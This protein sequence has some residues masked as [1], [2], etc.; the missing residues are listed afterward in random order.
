MWYFFS[1]VLMGAANIIPGVSG[2]TIAVL[3]G[4]YD[5]LIEA[6]NSLFSRD[7]KSLKILLPAGFG[8]LAG[9][10]GFARL[11]EIS[12]IRYPVPT[13]FFFV[14]L[15]IVS[16]VKAKEF[17]SLSLKNLIFFIFGILCVFL[18]SFSGGAESGGEGLFVLPVAGFVAAAAMVVPGISGS[19]ILLMFGVYDSILSMV[20]HLLIDKLLVFGSGVVLGI[21]VSIKVMGFLLR[22]FREETYS[23]IG[24]MILASLYR[25]FPK[26][27]VLED[28]F[29]SVLT[30]SASLVFGFLLLKLERRLSAAQ[31][32]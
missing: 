14:G 9:V 24:G 13:H 21:F 17:F 15:V 19:L 26:E 10:F 25:V 6:I 27:I 30:L 22:R 5:R 8:L 2:G 4:I 3:M 7:F 12:L 32:P 28:L 11:L 23:F 29:P 18:L 16:F 20:S 1:G 31:N